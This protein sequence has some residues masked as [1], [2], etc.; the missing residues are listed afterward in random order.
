MA[1]L[2][3]D[4]IEAKLLL[5]HHSQRE[6]MDAY[7]TVGGIPEYLNWLKVDSSVFL[8]LCQHAFKQN[9]LVVYMK[10]NSLEYI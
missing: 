9:S 2:K 1:L 10:V 8:S 5:E 4:L 3:L 6:I 7:L